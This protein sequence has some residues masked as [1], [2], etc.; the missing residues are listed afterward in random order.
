[1]P[2]K[3]LKQEFVPENRASQKERIIFHPSIFS[4]NL[5]VS[6]WKGTC[7]SNLRVN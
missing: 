5:A 2:P 3:T 1:M 7:P 4:G 6:F